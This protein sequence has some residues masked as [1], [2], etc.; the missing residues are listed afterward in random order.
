MTEQ[1]FV[2]WLDD[3][4]TN[5]DGMISKEELRKALHDLGLHFTRWKA[6]RGMAHGDLNHNHYIDGHEELEKLIA[7]AKNRWGIV[8]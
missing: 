8:N 6:G 5:K 3:I 7:Y 4:D 1:Q 2:Q